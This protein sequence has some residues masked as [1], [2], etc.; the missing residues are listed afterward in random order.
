MGDCGPSPRHR[1]CQARKCEDGTFFTSRGRDHVDAFRRYG[2]S[3][4]SKRWSGTWRYPRYMI[5]IA[6]SLF[7]RLTMCFLI[8][9]PVRCRL[10]LRTLPL[11]FPSFHPLICSSQSLCAVSA[12]QTGV[13]IRSPSL[14]IWTQSPV[15]EHT[16]HRKS[17]QQAKSIK[18]GQQYDAPS[19]SEQSASVEYVHMWLPSSS[20][21]TTTASARGSRMKQTRI[22]RTEGSS[23]SPANRGIWTSNSW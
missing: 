10:T 22:R 16:S 2:Y 4:T 8:F 14:L 15:A 1:P 19:S 23:S 17:C 20:A 21:A 12:V 5:K 3:H 13:A 7:R 9:S 18:C 6:M 11:A